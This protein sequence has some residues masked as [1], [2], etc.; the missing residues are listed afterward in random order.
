MFKKFTEKEIL[1]SRKNKLEKYFIYNIESSTHNNCVI[2]GF[3]YDLIT[4]NTNYQKIH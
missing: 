4:H 2:V 1:V 3:T